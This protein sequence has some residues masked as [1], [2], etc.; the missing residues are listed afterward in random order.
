MFFQK[1]SVYSFHCACRG[2]HR[3]PWARQTPHV[4]PHFT[5]YVRSIRNGTRF[6]ENLLLINRYLYRQ[7]DRQ[8]ILEYPCSFSSVWIFTATSIISHVWQG[9]RE[10]GSVRVQ[11]KGRRFTKMNLGKEFFSAKRKRVK[12]NSL[13]GTQ[14]TGKEMAP[15]SKAIN[16]R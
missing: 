8:M 5:P 7:I 11:R 13:C 2:A 14:K 3:F 10:A 12:S 6:L 9:E 16:S 1:L 15:H 4:G